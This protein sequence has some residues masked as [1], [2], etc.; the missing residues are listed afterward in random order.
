[1]IEQKA[2]I[3][4]RVSSERQKKEGHGL[5]SQ[6]HRC[7][8][9]AQ[10]H[11]FEVEKVFYDSYTGEGNFLKRPAM[12][13]LLQYMDANTHTN[14][15]VIFDDLK[16]FARDVIF[17]FQLRAEFTARKAEPRCLNFNFED[18]PEGH[19]V[20]TIIAATGELERKQ[21]KRQ[22]IQKMKARL[23]SGY[24]AFNAPPGYIYSRDVIHGKLLVP[25]AKMAKI[26]KEALEGFAYGRFP[27][28][29]DVQQFLAS[30]KFLGSRRIYLEYVKRLLTRPIYA[31]YIDYPEWNITRRVGHHKALIS[32]ETYLLIEEKLDGR[33]NLWIRQN[34]REDFPL[35]GVIHCNA[36][37]KP[38]TASW[39]KGRSNRYAYYRCNNWLCELRNKSIPKGM[40]ENKFASTLLDLQPSASI[41]NLVKAK[42]LVQWKN[43]IKNFNEVTRK[44]QQE[45]TLLEN[46][47]T[48][49]IN[50]ISSVQNETV[51]K[52]Y[53]S[54][55]EELAK[56][57]EKL[58]GI[59]ERWKKDRPDFGTALG[60]FQTQQM[61]LKLLFISPICFDLN[62]GFGTAKVSCPIRV[63][64]EFSISNSRDV[65]I[66]CEN[67]NQSPSASTQK[68]DWDELECQ[69]LAMAEMLK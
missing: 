14:Y 35:R 48:A 31:G 34:R 40:I 58:R 36:C 20:E 30:Q 24:W 43:K 47:M 65:D 61:L 28:Q 54:Q 29:I 37:Q 67:W 15:V 55:I 12:S 57:A 25:D 19:Y 68:I 3:Y 50:R 41:L 39:S 38:L 4:T 42:L 18:T 11:G 66:V 32:P 62:Y 27:N 53:D 49:M 13:A 52:M 2:L 63:L 1:M 23:E 8:L 10:M 26:I 21:N 56:K 17:H 69:I 46:S 9:Y 5:E 51:L 7:R 60:N 22:V 64:R 16:R 45:L 44:Q 33:T 59:M 6:E